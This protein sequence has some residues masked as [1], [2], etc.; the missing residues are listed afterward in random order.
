MPF[1]KLQD[2]HARLLGDSSKLTPQEVRDLMP[3]M[4][5]IGKPSMHRLYAELSLQNLE[6]VQQF[7]RSSSRLSRWMT[8]L[9]V[10]LVVLTSLI[11][12]YTYLL[13]SFG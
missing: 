6:V 1:P 4:H 3:W 10:V 8:G 5:L 7:E 2:A 13:V 12:Y 11:A 9:T